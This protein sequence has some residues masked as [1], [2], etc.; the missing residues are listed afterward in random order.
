M[1]PG[2]E[3]DWRARIALARQEVRDATRSDTS[4]DAGL[5][6]AQAREARL[7]DAR[8]H[9]AL[10]I[11]RFMQHAPLPSRIGTIVAFAT[12]ESN[13]PHRRFAPRIR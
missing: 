7:S 3:A 8:C 1:P 10:R 6:F 11:K 5:Q 12:V 4:T 13:R 9:G 2:P